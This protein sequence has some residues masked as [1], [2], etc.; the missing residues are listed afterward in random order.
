[1]LDG[2][3]QHLRQVTNQM[4]RANPARE[5]TAWYVFQ[6]EKRPVLFTHHGQ[7]ARHVWVVTYVDPGEGFLCKA[8]GGGL[9]R[10]Q[11]LAIS[12]C[13]AGK[14]V[15]RVINNVDDPHAALEDLADLQD[16]VQA[17]ADAQSG[18]HGRNSLRAAGWRSWWE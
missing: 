15:P 10:Q 4:R 1:E 16:L 17:L 7:S 18:P 6:K 11:I 12:F 9:G 5:V 13:R 14:M 2:Q 8:L 3:A